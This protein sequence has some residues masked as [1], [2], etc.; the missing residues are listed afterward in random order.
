MSIST[1][2]ITVEGMTCNSCAGKVRGALEAVPGI[3]KAD[4]DHA[5]GQVNIHPDGTVNS[6]DLEF[7]IDEAIEQTGYKVV[8]S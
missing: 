8:S 3:A 6:D 7:D 1:V 4:V 2:D 5:S